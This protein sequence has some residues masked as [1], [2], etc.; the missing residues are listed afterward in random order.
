MKYKVTLKVSY[1]TTA[2]LF[3]DRQEALDFAET[4]WLNRDKRGDIAGMDAITE[5]PKV[6]FVEEE[7]A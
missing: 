5:S 6:S 1:L 2:F 4:A 7:E 3:D